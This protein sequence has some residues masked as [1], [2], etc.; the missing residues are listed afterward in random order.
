[1]EILKIGISGSN[2]EDKTHKFLSEQCAVRGAPEYFRLIYKAS[3][4]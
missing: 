2:K 1:M 3:L 4:S